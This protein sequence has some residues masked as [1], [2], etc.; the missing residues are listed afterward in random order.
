MDGDVL[1]IPWDD[2]ADCKAKGLQVLEIEQGPNGET[3]ATANMPYDLYQ[4][5]TA[6]QK[7]AS[8]KKP[9]RG[10]LND[11]LAGMTGRALASPGNVQRTRLGGGLGI[12]LIY[13][14]DGQ[15]RMQIWRMS[16]EPSPNEWKTVL[17]ACSNAPA[18]VEPEKFSHL[19]R[20]Y[21]RGSWAQTERTD[22]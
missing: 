16:K 13:G 9:G 11:L 2:L 18:N 19:G 6:R 17:A 20:M 10:S 4:A 12:D 14:I 21:L 3:L 7:P 15:Y 8:S 5:I 22:K 1:S